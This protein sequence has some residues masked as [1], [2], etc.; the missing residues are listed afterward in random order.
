[1]LE[2]QSCDNTG[3]KDPLLKNDCRKLKIQKKYQCLILNA[4]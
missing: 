1:M 2:K 3:I 4:F